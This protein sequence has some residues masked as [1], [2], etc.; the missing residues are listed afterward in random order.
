MSTRTPEE[1]E[2]LE[3]LR[4]SRKRQRVLAASADRLSSIG[5]TS[6][7]VVELPNKIGD[8]SCVDCVPPTEEL[9]DKPATQN[10]PNLEFI[11]PQVTGLKKPEKSELQFPESPDPIITEKP[12]S[13]LE[14]TNPSSQEI[15]PK[16]SDGPPT[17]SEGSFTPETPSPSDSLTE[18]KKEISSSRIRK[19]PPSQQ[20]NLT[21]KKFSIPRQTN[22]Y[23]LIQ[24]CWA[25]LF[26]LF[27]FFW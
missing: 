26:G 11:A 6:R 25:T 17:K 20:K 18:L 3:K 1:L 23:R 2:K 14:P 16:K 27:L 7:E 21:T 5:Q 12:E 22:Y 10:Q 24:V 9:H 13:T 19:Q 4:Q 15:K 8:T